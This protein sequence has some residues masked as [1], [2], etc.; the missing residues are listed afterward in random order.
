MLRDEEDPDT[1]RE[2]KPEKTLPA[3]PSDPD[4]DEGRDQRDAGEEGRDANGEHDRETLPST[5]TSH[6]DL[7]DGRDQDDGDEVEVPPQFAPGTP[8][9]GRPRFDFESRYNRKAWK[10]IGVEGF[11]LL[12]IFAVSAVVLVLYGPKS[13]SPNAGLWTRE[14]WLS[15]RPYLLAFFG[16]A[17]G[18][19]LF[20]LKW[21]YHSVAKGLW[22]RDRI[23]WRLFTPILGGG[24]AVTLVVLSSSGVV[25]LFGPA[26]AKSPA[27]S[28]G[29]SLITG[30][31]S[32]RAFSL[33]ENTTQSIFGT[34]KGHSSDRQG[35]EDE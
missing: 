24:A 8:T 19:T 18:G 7:S 1:Q 32:D 31:F 10:Q 27:G 11:Y 6:P 9:D 13:S 22:N 34:P 35:H 21:L 26:L 12:V 28:V 2:Q 4:L 29:I 25:P 17:L 15:A 14:E 20:A 5:Q 3:P 33:F 30:F 16:G 23:L